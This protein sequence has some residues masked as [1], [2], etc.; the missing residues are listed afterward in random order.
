MSERGPRA[1]R[2]RP[3]PDRVRGDALRPPFRTEQFGTVAVLGNTLGFAGAEG[4][5]LLRTAESLV[6]PGGALLVEVAPGPGERS[7]YL[8]RLPERSV[9]RL[10]RSPTQA[11]IPRIFREGFSTEPARKAKPGPFL[12]VGASELVTDLEHR[13]WK[14]G[15]VLAVA[16]ALGP[17]PH[18]LEAARGDPKA[19]DHLLRIEEE[20]GRKP[21]RWTAAAAV[22]VAA[23]G[24]PSMRAIK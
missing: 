24:K 6:A 7:R 11:V 21:E 19:W 1:R 20:L 15:E 22:L 10:L 8:A 9:A 13:G 16:P 23:Q 4:P 14:V 12:R 18:R 3:L 5:S 2:A 17:D